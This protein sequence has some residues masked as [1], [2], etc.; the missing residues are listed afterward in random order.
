M[1]A[2][3][4]VFDEPLLSRV[5]ELARAAGLTRS[6]FIRQRIEVSLKA[7][8]LR[9]ACEAERRAYQRQPVTAAETR[10]RKALAQASRRVLQ[11]EDGDW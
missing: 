2:V 7:D 9:E 10:T 4:V 1:K 3:Q 5:D 11:K 8:Q 6:A